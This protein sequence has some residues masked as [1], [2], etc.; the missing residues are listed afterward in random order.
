MI[1]KKRIKINTKKNTKIEINN[2]DIN[3]IWNS[4]K[5][6]DQRC[7]LGFAAIRRKFSRFAHFC[8]FVIFW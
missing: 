6:F 5:N 4:F 1:K 2:K 3:D 8:T 7:E